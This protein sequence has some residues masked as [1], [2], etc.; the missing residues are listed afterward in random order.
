M[1]I[2]AATGP[3]EVGSVCNHTFV[4]TK[5]GKSQ[6]V[7]QPHLILAEATEDEYVANCVEH[8]MNEES[9]RRGIVAGLCYFYRISVD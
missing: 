6:F 2:L 5:Q 9:V 3:R 8:G 4:I 7:T 1:I